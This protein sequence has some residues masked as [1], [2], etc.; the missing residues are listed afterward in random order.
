[1]KLRPYQNKAS[2]CV[3]AAWQDG[4][5]SALVVMPTGAGK[6]ILFADIIR[7]KLPGRTMVLSHRQELT[8]QARDKIKRVTGL[9]VDVEMGEYKSAQDG[10][11]FHPRAQVIVSTIQTH[12]AG[13]DGGGR[14][15]KFDPMD[16]ALLIIDEAHHATSPSY[17]RV[18]EY[19]KSNP[20]LV[21]L[22]VT[23]TPDRA[24]EE[25]LGQVFEVVAFDY[26]ILD[27]INDGWLV[28]IDQQFVSVEDLDY[29]SVRTTAGDLNN[30]DL[31]EILTAEKPLHG[32]ADSTI[33]IVG[34][35]RGLGFSASVSHAEK[36]CEIFNRHR[37]GMAAVVS[38]KTDKDER[39]RIVKDFAQGSIQWLWNCGV[40]TEG[41]DDSGVEVIAMARP[42]KSRALY[43]QMAGRG[44]RP[45]ES[46]A[47]KLN[48][49][50]VAPLRRAT[51]ARSI[52]PA[53]LIIDFVGN[54]GKHK[55]C[56]TA[57]ILGGNVSDEVLEAAVK[58]LQR[59]GKPGRM[60]KE[61]EE[62]EKRQEEIKAKRLEAEARRLRLVAKSTFKT[63][64]INPF[65]VLQIKPVAER[66]WGKGKILSEGQKRILREKMGLNPDEF[67]YGQARQL[68][69]KQFAIWNKAKESGVFAPT[70]KMMATL[71]KHGVDATNLSF[72]QASATIDAI[73][74]NGWNLPKG[75]VPPIDN[76]PKPVASVTTNNEPLIDTDVPF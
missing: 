52:K 27:A 49:V 50:P 8:W 42:T 33:Q 47:S 39:Q 3:I 4:A 16:F 21:V 25:A 29:S 38:A 41:F 75:F 31:D 5:C 13:G 68:L 45:H 48:N 19:Y 17:R 51:I 46:I 10:S 30:S 26:E 54:S 65:D 14:M 12:T 32:V 44:T 64:R 20:N 28:P 34:N 11:L 53:C 71:K 66:G 58:N 55:L 60:G 22:G 37:P 76:L 43:A 24:D 35:K 1:M 40:F 9:E 23:A 56:T 2:D 62:E 6:T 73:A 7:R 15:G 18:I 63:Q 74:K 72:K 59:S 69:D 67:T 61:I 70:F 57:D 36:L